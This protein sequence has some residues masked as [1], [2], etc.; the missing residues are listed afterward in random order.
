MVE[1]EKSMHDRREKPLLNARKTGMIVMLLGLS[2]FLLGGC[3]APSVSP[4][5]EATRTSLILGPAPAATVPEGAPATVAPEGTPTALPKTSGNPKPPK[6]GTV[7]Y[8]FTLKDMDGNEVSLSNFRGKKVML[9][10]WATWCAPCRAEIPHMVKLYGERHD[11][12]FEIIAVN[13]REGPE[14]VGPFVERLHMEFPVLLDSSGKVGNAYSV[15]GIPT[16]IFLDENGVIQAVHVGTLTDESLQKY[17][18]AL[19][20]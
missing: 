9:N 2:A 3:V 1:S 7:A 5:P 14:R 15:R 18:A 20:D 13:L 17:V 10:F 8:D 11:E 6:T 19:I 16:S 12:G 4:S